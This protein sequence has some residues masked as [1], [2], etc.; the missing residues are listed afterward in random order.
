M[1]RYRQALD[2]ARSQDDATAIAR[3]RARQLGFQHFNYGC[4]NYLDSLTTTMPV[5]WSDPY[6]DE[7][8]FRSDRLVLECRRRVTPVTVHEVLDTPPTTAC[9][10]QMEAPIMARYCGLAVPV[11]CPETGFAAAALLIEMDRNAFA[12]FEPKVRGDAMALVFDYHQA[13]QKFLVGA[14]TL[15]GRQSLS[16][17]ERQILGWSARGKTSAEIAVIERLAEATVN[18]HMAAIRRKLKVSSRAEAIAVAI[19]SGQIARPEP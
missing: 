7:C 9:Q 16:R 6:K 13:V 11:H 8:F 10:A 1:D 3:A 2:K 19:G 5:A 18:N 12:R 15:D 4:F 17:R 14:P